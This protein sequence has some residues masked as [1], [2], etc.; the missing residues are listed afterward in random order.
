M[1]VAAYA[2]ILIAVQDLPA[3]E[4]QETPVSEIDQVR[5]PDLLLGAQ[6]PASALGPAAPPPNSLFLPQ[7]GGEELDEEAARAEVEIDENGA[8]LVITSV[9]SPDFADPGDVFNVSV[10]I[11]NEGLRA[12]PAGSLSEPGYDVRLAISTDQAVSMRNLRMNVGNDVALVN[13]SMVATPE[14]LPA[15]IDAHANA[16]ERTQQTLEF[17]NVGTPPGTPPGLYF[18][19]AAVDVANAVVEQN[20]DNNT[21]CTPF[22]VR[23]GPEQL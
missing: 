7:V 3:P 1:L 21:S 10:T 6:R 5:A 11:A 15:G 17:M 14:I 22:F 23:P 8:D 18:I 16:P 13:G 20:E 2:A 12:A 4:R 9:R 19:C